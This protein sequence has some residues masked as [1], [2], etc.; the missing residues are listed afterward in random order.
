MFNILKKLAKA[1]IKV[2][3]TAIAN[4]T[5]LTSIASGI[6]T[7][8][9]IGL[10]FMQLRKAFKK[11]KIKANQTVTEVV[12]ENKSEITD[13]VTDII[14]RDQDVDQDIRYH[15][16]TQTEINNDPGVAEVLK[17][18]RKSHGIP[19]PSKTKR[20]GVGDERYDRHAQNEPFFVYSK[21]GS[22]IEFYHEM[23]EKQDREFCT[24]L[25]KRLRRMGFI[26]G[27]WNAN[28]Y[29]KEIERLYGP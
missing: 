28:P 5:L 23:T 7:A 15:G 13:R 10:L 20:K 21:D 11:S 2:V 8:A 1:V 18:F 14:N 4:G 19:E 27:P 12:E 17:E 29:R 9:G 6:S 25:Y 3:S 16:Y 26:H 24:K 22:C